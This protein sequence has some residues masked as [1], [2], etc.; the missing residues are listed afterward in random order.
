MTAMRRDRRTKPIFAVL[1]SFKQS[2]FSG[3]GEATQVGSVKATTIA[4]RNPTAPT[5]YAATARCG[6]ATV[7]IPSHR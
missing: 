3:H 7:N 1:S 6:V 2:S 5:T 4:A